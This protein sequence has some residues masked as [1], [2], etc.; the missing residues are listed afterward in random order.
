MVKY[1]CRRRIDIVV[2]IERFIPSPTISARKTPLN[3]GYGYHRRAGLTRVR[4]RNLFKAMS[5]TMAYGHENSR[6][7]IHY[8]PEEAS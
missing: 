4:V 3:I 5:H 1:L 7:R 8:P 2:S 6:F